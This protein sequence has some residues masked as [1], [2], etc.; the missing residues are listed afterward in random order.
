MPSG[1]V[2]VLLQHDAGHYAITSDAGR[3]EFR[4]TAAAGPECDR[5]SIEGRAMQSI[6]EQSVAEM[7][8]RLEYTI[9][10]NHNA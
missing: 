6:A 10:P 1:K 4:D 3:R 9:W 8:G 7:G 5:P 2:A